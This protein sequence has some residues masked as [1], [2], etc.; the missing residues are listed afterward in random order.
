MIAVVLRLLPHP[1]NMAPI[2]AMAL[3]GGVYLNKKYALVF[4]LVALFISDIFLGF[5]ASMLTVYASFLL[6]GLMGIWLSKRKKVSY[7]ATASILSSII[8]YLLTNFNYFYATSLYP[9]TLTGL[10]ESYAAAVPFFRN[11]LLGDLIYTGL[12]FGAYETVRL[13]LYKRRLAIKEARK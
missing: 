3:F 9:K 6:T 5:H 1:A 8:F 2:A 13:I 10:A 4:P 7:I 11:T 12:F